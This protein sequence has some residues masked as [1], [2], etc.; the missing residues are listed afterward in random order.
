MLFVGP[1][2]IF[3]SKMDLAHQYRPILTTFNPPSPHLR[4][5]EPHSIQGGARER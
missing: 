2:S 1:R 5:I 3:G 4:A